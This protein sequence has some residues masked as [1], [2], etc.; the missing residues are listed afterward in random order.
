MANFHILEACIFVGYIPASNFGVQSHK[1][2][3]TAA[4]LAQA[5]STILQ[6]G[7]ERLTGGIY[8]PACLGQ[9]YVDRLEEVGVK[10]E[11]EIQHV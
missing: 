3:V 8:T 1:L 4:L 6:D 5:A 7:S 2:L 9:G 11:A 10:F